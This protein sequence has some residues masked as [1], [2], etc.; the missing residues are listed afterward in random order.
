MYFPS[1]PLTKA[2]AADGRQTGMGFFLVCFWVFLQ[3]FES[4]GRPA[5]FPLSHKK[6]KKDK[7]LL[8][9][10]SLVVKDAHKEAEAK[11]GW[12]GDN[13]PVVEVPCKAL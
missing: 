12:S 1:E 4:I 3:R 6:K 5:P 7:S 9:D 10:T 2:R 13:H 8:A 11:I